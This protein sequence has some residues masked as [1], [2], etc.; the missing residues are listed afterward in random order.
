MSELPTRTP[1]S[2]PLPVAVDSSDMS[3]A[4]PSAEALVPET[5]IRHPKQRQLADLA[6]YGELKQINREVFGTPGEIE[7]TESVPVR[8][9]G[10]RDIPELIKVRNKLEKEKEIDELTGLRNEF[11]LRNELEMRI[12][13]AESGGDKDFGLL[14]LDLDGF[15][16]VNDRFN[17]TKGDELLRTFGRYLRGEHKLDT[18]KEPFKF[19]KDEEAFRLHGD[20]FAIL[21]GTK[22]QNKDRN[23]NTSREDIAR[24]FV[25]RFDSAIHDIGK[26]IHKRI[27][28]GGSFGEAYYQAGD[29]LESMIDRADSQMYRAK[30][31]K[32]RTF[33]K[34][35]AQMR[36]RHSR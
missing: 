19:R 35:R 14:Y 3:W 8:I 2:L 4:A 33:T 31:D 22:N 27:K 15:K 12:A 21:I 24:G 26:K 23:P 16:S 9:L 36:T 11:G 17:H 1:K 28:V 13:Q 32:R 18:D 29:T 5:D 20:E 25:E 10:I 30:H 6:L 7:Q 34:L